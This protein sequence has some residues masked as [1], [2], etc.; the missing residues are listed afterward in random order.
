MGIFSGLGGIGEQRIFMSARK[1]IETS[2]KGSR[3]FD[4]VVAGSLD[5]E[6][7]HALKSQSYD[8]AS[9]LSNSITSGAVSPNLIPDMLSLINLEYKVIDL[10]FVLAKSFKRHRLDNAVHRRYI[11]D[12]LVANNRLVA[13][14]L[15]ALYAM[16]TVGKIDEIKKLRNRVKLLEEEG[17]EIKED[18][19]S[20]AYSAKT[21]YKSFY[22]MTDLAYLSDDLLDSCED[23][24]E[25]V[26]NIMLSIAT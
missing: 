22:H 26:A 10:L 12:Q 16:H 5:I 4:Q 11:T 8:D 23:T 9:N 1:L 20:Y 3:M 17:D 6:K 13:R 2:Q 24:A 25:M 21:D 19:L 14:S 18:M 7:I 15:E